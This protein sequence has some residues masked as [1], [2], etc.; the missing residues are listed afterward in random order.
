M[1]YIKT[2]EHID[3]IKKSLQRYWKIHRINYFCKIKDCNRKYYAKEYCYNHYIQLYFYPIHK[4]ECALS[5]RKYY[6]KTRILG[7]HKCFVPKCN[8]LV[9]KKYKYCYR[10]NLRYKKHRSLDL[11]IKYTLKG[12]RNPMWKGGIAEYPNHYLMKKNRLI[13]LLHNPICEICNKKPA[14]EVH[15]KNG[16][17]SDHR[18]SNLAASCRKCNASI[19]FKPN[20][21]KYRR[22]YGINMEEIVEKLHISNYIFYKLHNQNGLKELLKNG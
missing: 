13:I 15:H 16:D 18:L 1:L 14:V 5:R 4:K 8:K 22:L 19:R 3:K 20:I 6:L 9:H 12:K 11:S 21:S 7:N 2:P 17:K 10:H